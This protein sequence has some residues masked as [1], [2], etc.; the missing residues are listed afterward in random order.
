ML[1][2]ALHVTSPASFDR[3]GNGL[4][5]DEVRVERRQRRRLPKGV[6]V[7]LPYISNGRLFVRY[8]N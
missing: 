3:A 6:F 1:E 8:C 7:I 5:L 2:K 4:V